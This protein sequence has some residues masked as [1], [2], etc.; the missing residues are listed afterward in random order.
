[1]VISISPRP[2]SCGAARDSTMTMAAGFDRSPSRRGYRVRKDDTAPIASA[3]A[4]P[5]HRSRSK[6]PLRKSKSKPKQLT[7]GIFP[8]LPERSSRAHF[9]FSLCRLQDRVAMKLLSDDDEVCATWCSKIGRHA[10]A[11]MAEKKRKFFLPELDTATP[12]T[13]AYLT[14]QPFT[15]AQLLIVG[16]R[17][18]VVRAS[19]HRCLRR[20]CNVTCDRSAHQIRRRKHRAHTERRVPISA[21]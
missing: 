13:P 17:T 5:L 3:S 2:A 10:R 4:T 18:A 8:R 14:L 12:R 1:M 11:Q 15:G 7:S 9:I 16:P 21:G 20:R 19:T 6:S